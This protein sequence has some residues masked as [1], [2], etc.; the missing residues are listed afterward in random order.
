MLGTNPNRPARESNRLRP[1]FASESA[2]EQ[3]AATRRLSQRA[4]LCL[5]LTETRQA[6]PQTQPELSLP[7]RHCLTITSQ[8]GSAWSLTDLR[9]LSQAAACGVANP[10]LRHVSLWLS[11]VS[12]GSETTHFA[13]EL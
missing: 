10:A 11:T 13:Q 12:D 1:P 3:P 8:V 9:R 4:R 2:I 7:N 5:G 6:A